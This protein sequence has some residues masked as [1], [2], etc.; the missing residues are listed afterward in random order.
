MITFCLGIQPN[1]KGLQSSILRSL[2]TI[3]GD[4]PSS[5]S[6]HEKIQVETWR[7]DISLL[8]KDPE[9]LPLAKDLLRN[10]DR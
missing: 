8:I 7:K 2:A 4:G 6:S 5:I 1:L 9:A 10:R 3:L